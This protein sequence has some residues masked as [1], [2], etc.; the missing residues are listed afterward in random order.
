[1]PYEASRG[2]KINGTWY[3]GRDFLRD[4]CVKIPQQV[5]LRRRGSDQN[6]K[7]DFEQKRQDENQTTAYPRIGRS[8]KR[9]LTKFASDD[10][11][12]K[13]KWMNAHLMPGRGLLAGDVFRTVMHKELERAEKYRRMQSD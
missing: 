10:G 5:D 8:K 4:D 1:M 11:A 12:L 9:P 3:D 6:L 13:A 7:L 2:F